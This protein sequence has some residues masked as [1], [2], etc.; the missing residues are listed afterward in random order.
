[1]DSYSY[2]D[3][4]TLTLTL[5]RRVTPSTVSLIA[6]AEQGGTIRLDYGNDPGITTEGGKTY[7]V[8]FTPL[9]PGDWR[10]RLLSEQAGGQVTEETV[11]TVTGSPPPP[12]PIDL[13][14]PYR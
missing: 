4:V 3:D 6:V 8:T 12:P 14:N 1:V 11:F 5:P 13:T 7:T 10:C 2:G 9:V